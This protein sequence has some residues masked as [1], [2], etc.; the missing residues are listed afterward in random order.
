V[1]IQTTG[2]I[3]IKEKP[4]LLGAVIARG[5]TQALR[6][7]SVYALLGNS[8]LIGSDHLKATLALWEYTETSARF[9]FGDRTGDPIVDRILFAL[10]VQGEMTETEINNLFGRNMKTARTQAALELLRDSGRVVPDTRETGGRPA[11]IW[12]ITN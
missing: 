3:R 12:R 11:I 4:G 10:R 8:R 5:E 7:A 2:P 1:K 6:L 9:I